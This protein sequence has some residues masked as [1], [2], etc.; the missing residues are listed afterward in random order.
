M[1]KLKN[2]I[3]DLGGVLINLDFSKTTSAFLDLGFPHF[4]KM[5]SQFKVDQLFE[6]L[7][8]GLISDKDF[9]MVM[10]SVGHDALK[11]G[12]IRDAWNGLL[13]DFREESLK[14]LIKLKKDYNLFLLSNTNSIHLEAV[15]RILK[16]QTGYAS[17]DFFFINCYY[18]HLMGLRKPAGE[19]YDFVLK[20]AGLKAAE[21][22]F[23]DDTPANID[24]AQKKG[25]KTHLLLPGQKIEDLVYS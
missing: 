24:A 9:Y 1:E 15:N 12:H 18:S 21:T 11:A 2:I 14:F 17:L 6:R 23:I 22:L 16:Q 10:L 7:E 5:Y 3:F 20:D 8:K 25:F 19:I 4:E 13:L